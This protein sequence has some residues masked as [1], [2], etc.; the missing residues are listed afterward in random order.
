MNS[1]K[2]YAHKFLE[3]PALYSCLPSELGD[4]KVLCIGCGS[5]EE[6]DYLAKRGATVVGLDNSVGLINIAKQAYPQIQFEVMDQNHL[7]FPPAS[8]DLVFSSLTIHYSA[9]WVSIF[10]RIHQ[11]LKPAGQ[12]LFS[13]HHPI[14][15]GAQTTRTKT[16]NSYLLGYRKNKHT[17]EQ[18]IF[19]DYLN[20]R[21][22][23]DRL[24]GE[25]DIIYY[26]KPIS[27]IFR[28][29][30]QT[31]FELIDFLEP[32]PI[33]EAKKEVPKFFEVYSRIPL[34]MIF[35]LQKV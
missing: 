35:N 21:A 26:H 29:I 17:Q 3:K 33:I 16:I 24:F 8:F 1:G 10:S 5:G 11:I 30:K 14:K 20:S 7:N 27:E 9:D 31:N 25:L 12:F 28:I 22:I 32:K 34:F 4:L 2:N 15:W 6:C 19:G 18:E 13:T 23:T